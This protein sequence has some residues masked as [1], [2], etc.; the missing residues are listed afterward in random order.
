[1]KQQ[2]LE[3]IYVWDAYCGWCHGFSNSL[4]EFHENHPELPLSVLSGG[5]FFSQPIGNFPHIPEAN[6][7]IHQ[8]TGAEFGPAYQSLLEDG[9]FVMDSQKAA[10]GFAALRSLAPDSTYYFASAMQQAFYHDG[11]SLSDPETYREIAA[12]NG[13]DPEAVVAQMVDEAFKKE[14]LSDFAKVR[15]LGVNGYP[16]LLLKKGKELIAFGGA[17]MNAEKLEARFESFTS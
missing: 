10:I 3:L 16:T 15:Q 5:L 8:L 9:T 14:A 13:L 11:K 7:R 17:A 2:N 4:K 1:M 6:Q 12:A